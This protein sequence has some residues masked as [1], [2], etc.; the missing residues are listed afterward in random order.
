[1]ADALLDF[2]CPADLSAWLAAPLCRGRRW[3]QGLMA[4]PEKPAGERLDPA[5]PGRPADDQR[6]RGGASGSCRHAGPV[7][8]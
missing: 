8:A 4:L 3:R 5:Q 2:Q 7:A 1:M 6:G